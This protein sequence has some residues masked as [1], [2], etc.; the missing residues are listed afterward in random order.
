MPKTHT[1]INK[2]KKYMKK[3]NIK[4]VNIKNVL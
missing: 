3:E 4:N 1:K 2:L